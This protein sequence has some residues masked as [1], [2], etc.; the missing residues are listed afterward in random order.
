MERITYKDAGVDISA[1]EEAVERIKQVVR[2]THTPRVL[3]DIGLFA[4]FFDGNFTGLRHPVLTSSIDGVGT[5]V[6]IAIALDRHDTVGQDLVNH[7]VNDVM[8]SGSSP[9]FFLDYIGTSQLKPAIVE[10]IITGIAKACRENQCALVG[11]EM[12]EMPGLYPPGE[13]DLVGAIVGVVDKDQIIDGT[14]I[15]AGDVLLGLP[16]SGLHTNGY[17]LARKV[18]LE[19]AGLTLDSHVEEL[20]TTLG[21]E[22]LRIHRSYKR[23]IETALAAG[24]V[25]GIAH[26]TGGGIEGNTRRLLAPGLKLNLR[27]GEWEEPPIF[28]LIRRLGRV[29]EEDMR[30][31]FNL[32]IG[33]VLICRAE[34][35]DQLVGTLR[36]I[37]E[38]PVLIGEVVESRA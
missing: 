30:R 9:L 26:I 35:A 8:T 29:P 7:C 5:K 4:G 36:G 16:S 24:G 19:H 32:G 10:Q 14:K 6:K 13:Y 38:T 28:Q 20:G 33:L 37:G 23:A 18:L 12:A 27:W 31:T 22:L 2:S 21:E 17:S 3:S 11:G 34:N 15:R 25:E 1:A